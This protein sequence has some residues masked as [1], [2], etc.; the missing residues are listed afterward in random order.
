MM[1]YFYTLPNLQAPKIVCSISGARV[2]AGEFR[3]GVRVRGLPVTRGVRRRLG[4]RPDW[5]WAAARRRWHLRSCGQQAGG[6]Q[7][8][9]RGNSNLN[10]LA[11]RRA[12]AADLPAET[13]IDRLRRVNSR[14]E[15]HTIEETTDIVSCVGWRSN[16]PEVPPERSSIFRHPKISIFLTFTEGTCP[17]SCHWNP[18]RILVSIFSDQKNFHV[19]TIWGFSLHMPSK[20]HAQRKLNH[21]SCMH[22]VLS[23][24]LMRRNE[25]QTMQGSYGRRK[26]RQ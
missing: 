24:H 9:Q 18:I 7:G 20:I 22:N 12:V 15:K 6:G 1:L 8:W 13:G 21:R 10:W 3:G 11:R 16:G 2:N 14:R 5:W 17:S 19:S 4:W 26:L 23:I 25:K